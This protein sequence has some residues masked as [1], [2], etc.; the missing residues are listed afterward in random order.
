MNLCIEHGDE[1]DFVA[2]VAETGGF[3]VWSRNNSLWRRIDGLATDGAN[4]ALF[5]DPD[6]I[7]ARQF[8]EVYEIEGHNRARSWLSTRLRWGPPRL[9]GTRRRDGVIYNV[10]YLAVGTKLEASWRRAPRTRRQEYVA[11]T[12]D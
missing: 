12:E 4:L 5:D 11:L 6:S 3:E 1:D 8:I 10:T 2:W 7:D 9:A